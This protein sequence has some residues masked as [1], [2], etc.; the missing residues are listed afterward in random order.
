MA[1]CQSCATVNGTAPRRLYAGHPGRLAHRY[2]PSDR[3]QIQVGGCLECVYHSATTGF[4]AVTTDGALEPWSYYAWWPTLATAASLWSQIEYREI[5]PIRCQ[6]GSS[7]TWTWLCVIFAALYSSHAQFIIAFFLWRGWTTMHCRY[8]LGPHAQLQLTVS[9]TLDIGAER[10]LG[11]HG[12]E[13]LCSGM[14]CRSLRPSGCIPY[15]TSQYSR[16]ALW[17]RQNS[18]DSFCCLSKHTISFPSA[19]LH[20]VNLW[21]ESTGHVTTNTCGIQGI[22]TGTSG[23]RDSIRFK[24]NLPQHPEVW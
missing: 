24:R 11:N 3:W 10:H 19:V 15:E 20:W 4:H 6:S 2:M 7:Q 5:A 17:K 16:T 18:C 14:W 1:D 9:W 23:S 8:S 13:G 22:V 12:V 21:Q